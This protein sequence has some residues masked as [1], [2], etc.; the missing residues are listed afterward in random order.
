[1]SNFWKSLPKPFF[2]LAP[3]EDVTDVV[4]REII[5]ETAK[6]DVF[7]TEFTSAEG[8]FSKGSGMLSPKLKF[9]DKQHPIVAQIW[10]KDPV[11][12]RKAA[13]LVRK[14]G[15]DGIDINMGCPVKVVMKK[16]S[17]AAHIGNYDNSKE[18]IDA[19]KEGAKGIAVSVKTRL[20][21]NKPVTEDW[22]S[23]LLEQKLDA[24]IIHGRIAVE[25]SK[26]KADWKEI[27]KAVKIKNNT[28]PDTLIIGNGDIKSWK[29]AVEM[30]EK[31]Q[32]DGIMIGRGIFSNPWVFEKTFQPLKR[33]KQTYIKLLINHIKLHGETYRN[34]NNFQ[35]LKKFFKMY[36]KGFDGANQT[37]QELMKCNNYSG[38]L[39]ILQRFSPDF[40]SAPIKSITPVIPSKGMH[41]LVRTVVEG[42]SVSS[43]S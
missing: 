34:S 6:P 4:F 3:M 22:I 17:G 12:M 24:L 26:N 31:Y 21:I 32:V 10:G 27:G 30:R 29:Q 36:V 20:G 16:G 9:T 1:M 13:K 33:N 2:V 5:A 19:V 42:S 40:I 35:V 41:R 15:F 18:I 8:L 43:K 23:F 11:C 37:R 39:E 7:F 25:M 28:Y 14:L 38:A